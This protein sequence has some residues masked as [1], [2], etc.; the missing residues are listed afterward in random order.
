MVDGL[1]K[2]YDPRVLIEHTVSASCALGN[3]KMLNVLQF[4]CSENCQLPEQPLKNNLKT[5]LIKQFTINLIMK[6]SI[7]IMMMIKK[8]QMSMMPMMTRH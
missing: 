8:G 5:N 6:M 1:Y 3:V 4:S 2:I 7:I